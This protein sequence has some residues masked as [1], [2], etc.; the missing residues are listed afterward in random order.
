MASVQSSSGSY[1][2]LGGREDVVVCAGVGAAG[3]WASMS[4]IMES[5]ATCAFDEEEDQ[6]RSLLMKEVEADIVKLMSSQSIETY[7]C[8]V[9]ESEGLKSGC[10]GVSACWG[11]RR[12]YPALAG[13]IRALATCW[14]AINVGGL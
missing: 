10:A 9:S 14:M 7:W 4:V 2:A 8:V 3:S 12:K 6:K 11:V 5:D 1:D 13:Y